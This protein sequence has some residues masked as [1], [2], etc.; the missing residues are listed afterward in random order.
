MLAQRNDTDV[1]SRVSLLAL[2]KAKDRHPLR[3][4]CDSQ[5]AAGGANIDISL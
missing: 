5:T 2:E 3:D 4:H 1:V